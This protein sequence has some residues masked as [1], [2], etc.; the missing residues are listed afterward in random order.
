[1]RFPHIRF[2]VRWVMVAVAIVVALAAFW[3]LFPSKTRGFEESAVMVKVILDA[4]PVGSSVETAR[5]F[6]EREGFHCTEKTNSS[7]SEDRTGIDYLYC[8]RSE[9]LIVQ[10]KWMVAIVHR[11]GKVVEV[12]A[13]TGL[14]GP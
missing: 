2:T 5:R 1:M 14:I 3:G 4:A 10:R 7:F 9:G 8:G 13:N 11:K 12:L 6:M